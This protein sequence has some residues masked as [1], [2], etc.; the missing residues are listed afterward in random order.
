MADGFALGK[1]P[2]C[3][4]CGG[5]RLRFDK[6]TGVYSCPGYMEDEKF[7]HCRKKFEFEDIKRDDWVE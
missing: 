6:K 7:I 3:S 5:G 2:R 4:S 1:I